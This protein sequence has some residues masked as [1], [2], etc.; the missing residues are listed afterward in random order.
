M[1]STPEQPKAPPLV[2]PEPEPEPFEADTYTPERRPSAISPPVAFAIGVAGI[3]TAA[4]G[5]YQMGQLLSDQSE[6]AAQ[7]AAVAAAQ[8]P[9]PT[10]GRLEIAS[11]PAGAS[12]TINGVAA[13]VTPLT[14]PD[15][16]PGRQEIVMTRDGASVMR[17]VDLT[18]GST[19]LVT[20]VLASPVSA[21]V[22]AAGAAAGAPSA[23]WLTFNSPIELRVLSGGRAR[24]STNGRV[25]LAEGSYEL[26]LVS[27]IYEIRQTVNARVVAG[28]GASVS[29]S[30]PSGT[31]S[32]NA[33]PWADVWVDGSP[34]G[35]TPLANLTLKVGTHQ[36]VFRH[37]QLG[38]RQQTVVVKAVTPARIGVDFGR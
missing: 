25:S 37:P 28:R 36:V 8:P 7:A 14:L 9:P 26:E 20:A 21:P 3:V 1:R 17:S 4:V 35:T 18:A 29:V 23:G 30:V 27:D 22:P 16:V 31:L 11:D 19:A 6:A 10:T 32:I 34:V 38:E 15:I 5:Y 24:G 13:G 12:V 33:L 2:L